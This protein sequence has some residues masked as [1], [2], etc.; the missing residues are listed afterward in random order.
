M[1][2]NLTLE[3]D[4][5]EEAVVTLGKL[6]GGRAAKAAAAPLDKPK[7]TLEERAGLTETPAESGPLAG[8]TL[9]K[10]TRKPRAD[11]GK[12]RGPHMGGPELPLDDVK[13]SGDDARQAEAPEA[14]AGVSPPPAVAEMAPTATLD[15]AQTA[16]EAV[17]KA[18]GLPKAQE[19]LGHF[20]VA[21]LRD[22]PAEKYGAFVA[23]V[24]TVLS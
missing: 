1:K 12:G 20:G 11:K 18:K 7:A 2:I 5:L 24:K 8:L 10:K 3:C 15:E 21:R 17:F 14:T 23:L 9:P 22:L 4:S 19:A 13:E 6:I 16:L